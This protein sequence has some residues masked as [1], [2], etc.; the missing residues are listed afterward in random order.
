MNKSYLY[1][2]RKQ[3][4]LHYPINERPEIMIEDRQYQISDLSERGMKALFLDDHE[5]PD[6]YPFAGHITY[7]NGDKT[8]VIGKVVRSTDHGF[9]AHFD[10]GV[11]LRQIMEDQI[12]L[13]AKY[14][15]LFDH[16]D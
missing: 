6:G 12:R 7:V 16:T 11:E 1:E 2:R 10:E 5:L 8:D 15:L 3:Y 14:P 9:S 13:K 4:R